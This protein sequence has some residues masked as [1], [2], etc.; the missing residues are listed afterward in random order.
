M[1]VGNDELERILENA[2]GRFEI[3]G[4]DVNRLMQEC[5]GKSR[6]PCVLLMK[7]GNYLE[8]RYITT[9]GTHGILFN[10]GRLISPDLN[11]FYTETRRTS[12]RNSRHM[13]S[14]GYPAQNWCLDIEWEHDANNM[15]KGF[16]KVNELFSL[17]GANNTQIEEI[18]LLVYPQDDYEVLRVPE[19][20]NPLPIVERSIAHFRVRN[21]S[22]YLCET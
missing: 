21:I 15:R 22:Q 4:L 5:G 9:S 7:R 17:T 12:P 20:P 11:L 6:V 1:D 13:M 14:P 18:W 10:D 2:D 3:D 19:P 16:S 8:L